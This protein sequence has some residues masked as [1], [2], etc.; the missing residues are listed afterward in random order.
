MFLCVFFT[1]APIE[2]ELFLNRLIWPVDGTL[3]GATTPGQSE[4]GYNGIEG[5]LHTSLITRW[6]PKG[7]LRIRGDLWIMIVKGYFTLHW[8]QEQVPHHQIQFNDTPRKYFLVG[9]LILFW[10]YSQPIL[11]LIEQVSKW[12]IVVFFF[13]RPR[14][15][16]TQESINLL[17]VLWCFLV[18]G[19]EGCWPETPGVERMRPFLQI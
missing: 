1:H 4:P 3:S 17:N 16:P 7:T 11:S 2:Y 14:T 9:V 8:S 6:D 12:Y 13:I 19:A 10:G 15:P 18:G 5:V